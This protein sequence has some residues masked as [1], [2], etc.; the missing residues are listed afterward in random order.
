MSRLSFRNGAPKLSLLACALAI[1][2]LISTF[3]IIANAANYTDLQAAC[4][5]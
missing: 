4:S 3:A 5:R 2:V 1:A